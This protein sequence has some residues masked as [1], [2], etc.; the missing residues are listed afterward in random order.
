ML[1]TIGAPQ[2]ISV[3]SLTGPND[4][5]PLAAA[6]CAITC[7]IETQYQINQCLGSCRRLGY[8]AAPP[9]ACH[10]RAGCCGLAGRPGA[11][12]QRFQLS[13]AFGVGGDNH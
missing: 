1:A 3:R 4:P 5:E 10:R 9:D 6:V 8:F 11:S 2:F 12:R 13:Q 7:A